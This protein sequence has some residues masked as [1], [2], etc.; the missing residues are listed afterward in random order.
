MY[1]SPITS[2]IRQMYEAVRSCPISE[3]IYEDCVCSV[4]RKTAQIKEEIGVNVLRVVASG[5]LDKMNVE[6]KSR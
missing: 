6:M 2:V 3:L 1:F 4:V 5:N